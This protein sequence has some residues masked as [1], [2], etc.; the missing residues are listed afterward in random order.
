MKEIQMAAAID[1]TEATTG[2][3]EAPLAFPDDVAEPL[4]APLAVPL[5]P[6]CCFGT[7]VSW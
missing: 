6:F 7:A 2:P 1:N 5:V 3:G 4:E